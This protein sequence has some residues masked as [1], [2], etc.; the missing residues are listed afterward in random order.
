MMCTN[1]QQNL[2]EER[3][4]FKFDLTQYNP[5]VMWISDSLQSPLALII[6]KR[7]KYVTMYHTSCYLKS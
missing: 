4:N 3:L 5:S 7:L 2:I 1:P 6:I